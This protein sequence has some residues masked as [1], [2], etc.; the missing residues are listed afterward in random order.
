MLREFRIM[1]TDTT[2]GESTEQST[3]LFSLI[4]VSAIFIGVVGALIGWQQ[5][6]RPRRELWWSDA[7]PDALTPPHGD[8]L[9]PHV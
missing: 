6:S 1:P 2:T 7:G 8:K 9:Q 3:A 5:H 4:A